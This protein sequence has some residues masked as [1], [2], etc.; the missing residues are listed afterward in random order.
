MGR[1]PY[2]RPGLSDAT[3]QTVVLQVNN[4]WKGHSQEAKWI[5]TTHQIH[6]LKRNP[7]QCQLRK[8]GLGTEYFE[9]VPC[10]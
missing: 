7:S 9:A 10:Q 3:L 6:H 8:A 4:P 2:L 1:L 5:S